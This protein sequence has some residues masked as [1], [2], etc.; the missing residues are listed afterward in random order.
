MNIQWEHI[1]P[2]E[3]KAVYK[4]LRLRK[5]KVGGKTAYFLYRGEEE[6]PE[7]TTS[8]YNIF[9]QNVSFYADSYN[10]KLSTTEYF[11]QHIRWEQNNWW[12]VIFTIFKEW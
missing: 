12:A 11:K 4:S 10:K 1:G 8:Y 5:K 9:M 2:G 3:E 7:F 6:T